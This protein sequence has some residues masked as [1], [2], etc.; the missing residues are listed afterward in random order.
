M[1]KGYVGVV[2]MDFG[3]LPV[4]RVS[5]VLITYRR[6]LE[7]VEVDCLVAAPVNCVELLLLQDKVSKL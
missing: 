4:D 6:V 1:K 5:E 3:V 7:G 2:S